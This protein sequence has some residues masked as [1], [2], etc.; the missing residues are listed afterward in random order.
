MRLAGLCFINEMTKLEERSTLEGTLSLAV[1]TAPAGV[2]VRVRA[3]TRFR[4]RVRVRVRVR[5]TVRLGVR[6]SDL[7]WLHLE[8]PLGEH[9]DHLAWGEGEGEGEGEGGGGG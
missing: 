8:E 9:V 1:R 6:V 5:V 3:R 2:R 4:A 7:T